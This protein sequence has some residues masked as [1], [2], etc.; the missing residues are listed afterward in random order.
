M[1][2]ILPALYQDP[3]EPDDVEGINS[4]RQKPAYGKCEQ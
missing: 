1:I 4:I 2:M 3:P